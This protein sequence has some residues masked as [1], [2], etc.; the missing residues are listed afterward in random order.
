M[1]ESEVYTQQ[2]KQVFRGWGCKGKTFIYSI[3]LMKICNNVT[4]I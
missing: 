4:I 1:T 2:K 3:S